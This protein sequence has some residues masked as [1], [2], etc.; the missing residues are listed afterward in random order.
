MEQGHRQRPAPVGRLVARLALL[1]EY[2]PA[3]HGRTRLKKLRIRNYELR[4]E[5]EERTLNS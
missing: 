4:M 1:G 3:L 2:D 5:Y